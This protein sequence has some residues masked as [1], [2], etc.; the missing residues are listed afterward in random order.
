MLPVPHLYAALSAV[1]TVTRFMCAWAVHHARLIQKQHGGRMELL[2][3][4]G[5]AVQKKGLKRYCIQSMGYCGDLYTYLNGYFTNSI[6]FFERYQNKQ[7]NG[8]EMLLITFFCD[9]KSISIICTQMDNQDVVPNETRSINNHPMG[10]SHLITYR[11]G[12]CTKN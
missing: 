3:Y 8:Y 7:L 11:M 6:T 9:S 5:F 1:F 2:P 12:Y 4:L 10:Y